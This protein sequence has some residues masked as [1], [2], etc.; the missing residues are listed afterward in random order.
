M[1][2]NSWLA[3]NL[4]RRTLFL[5]VSNGANTGC[6]T[7]GSF[8]YSTAKEKIF[9]LAWVLTPLV[10]PVHTSMTA[11]LTHIRSI[12]MFMSKYRL[13][14]FYC[15]EI[16]TTPPPGPPKKRRNSALLKSEHLFTQSI[17]STQFIETGRSLP[18]I[19]QSATCTYPEPGPYPIS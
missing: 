2:G 16:L 7:P 10:Q 12:L 4:L 17:N 1:R 13:K 18:C 6:K 5:G 19:Q 11:F 14:G 9:A 8:W 15:S 3:E